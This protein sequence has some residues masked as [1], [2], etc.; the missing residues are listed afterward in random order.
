MYVWLIASCL[1]KYPCLH[2]CLT[3]YHQVFHPYGVWEFWSG[4]TVNC[5]M[6]NLLKGCSCSGVR[7]LRKLYNLLCVMSS[8]INIKMSV[9][10]MCEVIFKWAFC[11]SICC[12]LSAYCLSSLM[13]TK[14]VLCVQQCHQVSVCRLAG[15]CWSEMGGICSVVSL[16]ES[17]NGSLYPLH[18]WQ[19]K[20]ELHTL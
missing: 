12:F 18:L 1:C 11:L 4:H 14:L 5:I 10:Y 20:V 9:L 7:S 19:L 16:F 13:S 2:F 8:K 15:E 6:V 3:S 17:R